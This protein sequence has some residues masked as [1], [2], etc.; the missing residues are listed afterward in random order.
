MV[1]M[2]L[3][4]VK[5]LSLEESSTKQAFFTGLESSPTLNF[6][7]KFTRYIGKKRKKK[8]DVNSILG[9]IAWF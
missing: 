6:W 4:I 7:G 5:C 8:L 3:E 9:E 1:E 2:A